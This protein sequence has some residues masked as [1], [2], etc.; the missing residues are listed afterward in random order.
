MVGTNCF[1]VKIGILTN[2]RECTFSLIS[3]VVSG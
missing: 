1:L 2:L 3:D